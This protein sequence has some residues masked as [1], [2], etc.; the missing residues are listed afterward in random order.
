[1]TLSKHIIDMGC[2][3]NLLLFL[4]YT[5]HNM[6]IFCTEYLDH[7]LHL[8]LDLLCAQNYDCTDKTR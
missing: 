5:A 8:F 6:H 2:F 1:M 4:D 7:I 3:Q